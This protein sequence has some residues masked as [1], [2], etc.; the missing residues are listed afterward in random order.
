MTNEKFKGKPEDLARM[1]IQSSISLATY[2]KK[3]GFTSSDKA[4]GR[5]DLLG[6]KE[7]P[8]L[9]GL[10]ECPLLA[11]LLNTSP[12]T[13]EIN[14]IFRLIQSSTKKERRRVEERGWRPEI[15]EET[16]KKGM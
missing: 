1:L 6:M 15:T 16:G 8:P 5:T 9:K 14:C 10:E 12:N 11:V 7:N 2:L 4:V 13:G 3:Y